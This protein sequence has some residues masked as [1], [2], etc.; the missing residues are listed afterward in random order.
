MPGVGCRMPGVLVKRSACNHRGTDIV[1]SL[2][3]HIKCIIPPS[4]AR[5]AS[6]VDRH[7]EVP[8]YQI[9][10]SKPPS[11]PSI[12]LFIV[13]SPHPPSIPVSSL[14]HLSPPGHRQAL[15]SS[16]SYLPHSAHMQIDVHPKHDTQRDGLENDM[17]HQHDSKDDKPH[18]VR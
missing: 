1:R 10:S 3:Y 13:Y 2:V 7:S 5:K 12:Q 9:K 15:F 16:C 17:K 11:T 4:A 18:T 6:Q 8:V 14:C